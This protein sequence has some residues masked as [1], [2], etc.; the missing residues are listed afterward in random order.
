MNSRCL[1]CF[2]RKTLLS[3]GN[4]QKTCP[5]CFGLGYI[6][7]ENKELVTELAEVMKPKRRR[8]KI[9]PVLQCE[10]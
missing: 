5:Y 7:E 9:E 8:K 10:N 6:K 2:G 4:M 3:L 1:S